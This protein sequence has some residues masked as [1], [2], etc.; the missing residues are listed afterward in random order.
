MSLT[1]ETIDLLQMEAEMMMEADRKTRTVAVEAATLDALITRLRE[2]EWLQ[3]E[4][5]RL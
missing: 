5:V 1:D 4:A 3:K 2:L